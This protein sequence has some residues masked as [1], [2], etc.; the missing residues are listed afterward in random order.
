MIV[1]PYRARPDGG[2]WKNRFLLHHGEKHAEID[3]SRSEFPLAA[4]LQ[5]IAD[6]EELQLPKEI[7]SNEP[8][9]KR[10]TRRKGRR[11]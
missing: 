11:S 2:K 3:R 4:L 9:G 1:T 7:P 8:K 10:N 5:A 6:A